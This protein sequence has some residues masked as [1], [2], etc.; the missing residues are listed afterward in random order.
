MRKTPRTV[1]QITARPPITPPTIAPM[2]VD[3][4]SVGTGVVGFDVDNGDVFDE[5]LE[6]GAGGVDVCV[7]DIVGCKDGLAEELLRAE[8][9]TDVVVASTV[10][11]SAK[12]LSVTALS[13]QAM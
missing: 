5:V 7:T 12:R 8:L 11:G 1:R 3:F 2:S 9:E 6:L 13:P 4:C 10:L